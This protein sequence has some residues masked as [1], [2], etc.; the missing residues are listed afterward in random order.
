MQIFGYLV[1]DSSSEPHRMREVTVLASPP[2][3][4]DLARFL[5]ACADEIERNSTDTWDHRHFSAFC[6]RGNGEQSDL[7]VVHPRYLPSSE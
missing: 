6:A 7:V 5:F 4:R 2:A 3:L 1:D